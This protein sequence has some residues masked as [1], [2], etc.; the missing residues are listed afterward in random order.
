MQRPAHVYTTQNASRM[1][2]LGNFGKDLMTQTSGFT[3]DFGAMTLTLEAA[4]V[5]R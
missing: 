2:I 4:Q 3:I 1:W 5:V